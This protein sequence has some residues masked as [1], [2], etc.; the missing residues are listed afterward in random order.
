MA[1]RRQ[2]QLER[3]YSS[4]RKFTSTEDRNY[5]NRTSRSAYRDESVTSHSDKHGRSCS[6][7]IITGSET[8]S[9]PVYVALQDFSPEEGDIDF[10]PI[11][12]GQ[13]VEVLD[14][15]NASKWLVRTKAR[16]PRTGWV[17]GS[18]F[19]TP[20]QFYK[21]RKITRE[22]SEPNPSLS[23]EEEA[24]QKRDQ[25]YGDLLKVEEEFVQ[26]LGNLIDDF[27]KVFDSPRVPEIIK[28]KKNEL[29]S[30][31]KELYN[32]HAHVL[33]K[34]L[35]YYSD[36]PGKV[37]HTFLRLEK[38]FDSHIIFEKDYENI[39]KLIEIPEIKDFLQI[40]SD[41]STA[42]LKTYQGYLDEIVN[43]I[44]QYENFFKEIIKYSQRANC[45]TKSMGKALEI[46]K[47]IHKRSND[48]TTLEKIENY[49]GDVTRLG[50]I[51]RQDTFQ[52]WER[53]TPI[54]DQ[55]LFLFKNKIMMVTHNKD[56]DTYKNYATLRL[57][58]YTVREHTIDINSFVIQP[59]ESGLPFFRLKPTDTKNHDIIIKAWVNDIKG[60]Q[61][62]LGM[63]YI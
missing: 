56:K 8:R 7:E 60:V 41:K 2:R 54:E 4:F 32:F 47:S 62:S 31:I 3:K 22:L 48:L 58:K 55:I 11:V 43:I 26:S 17:P 34:G 36:N 14:S 39:K 40:I 16:P 59:N 24:I 12:E 51:L 19:E 9:Y 61:E 38:D 30:C 13:I 18:Y 27:I 23:P 46:I 1:L 21:Q 6:T 45:S 44:S 42:G 29:T 20:T 33:L 63:F 10:I 25:A 52:V 5:R 35:E 50:E 28:D 53:E 37:G 57:D 49:S 15:K